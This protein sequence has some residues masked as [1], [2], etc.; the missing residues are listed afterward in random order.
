M[1]KQL[2]KSVR[3]AWLK[4]REEAAREEALMLLKAVMAVGDQRAYLREY[5]DGLRARI[6]KL[7]QQP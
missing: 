2:I 1:I 6:N 7:E 4:W 5:A 3:I